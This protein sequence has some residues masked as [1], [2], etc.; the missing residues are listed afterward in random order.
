MTPVTA[1]RVQQFPDLTPPRVRME[2]LAEDATPRDLVA[3]LL[4]SRAPSNEPRI[5]NF[6]VVMC[7][8]ES[9]AAPFSLATFDCAGTSCFIDNQRLQELQ[10]LL[11]Q[12]GY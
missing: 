2:I 1:S 9:T 8:F 6:G 3:A 10:A 5:R 4:E 11:K 12:D 7:E